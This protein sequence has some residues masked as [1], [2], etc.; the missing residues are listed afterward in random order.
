MSGAFCWRVA[1]RRVRSCW[2]GCAM[3]AAPATLRL[4]MPRRRAASSYRSSLPI[5]PRQTLL[6]LA[7]RA[8]F[9]CAR[10]SRSALAAF[11]AAA[12]RLRARHN[13]GRRSGG[14]QAAGRRGVAYQR[15]SGG[16]TPATEERRR[17]AVTLAK[18]KAHR[19]ISIGWY[20]QPTARRVATERTWEAVA[21][22]A[23]AILG[24]V[25]DKNV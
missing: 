23:W 5:L 14:K 6:L 9:A 2:R 17:A 25:L 20:N 1:K 10:I 3:S 8:A 21:W 16:G 12:A 13:C 11:R 24:C 18:V 15:Y 19:L 4:F 22:Q 7:A